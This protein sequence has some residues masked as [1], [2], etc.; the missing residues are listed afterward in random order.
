MLVGGLA[1]ASL[2]AFN[3]DADGDL[4]ATY[5]FGAYALGVLAAWRRPI[6]AEFVV[7]PDYKLITGLALGYASDD[8]VNQFRAEHPELAQVEPKKP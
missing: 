2:L 4:W 7:P 8:H 6:D 5:V 3:L 1:L